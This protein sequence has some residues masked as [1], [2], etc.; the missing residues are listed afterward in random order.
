[1]LA[2]EP[3]AAADVKD[4]GRGCEGEELQSALCH[5]G[6]DRFDS[7]GGG[8]FIRFGVIVE[9]VWGAVAVLVGAYRANCADVRSLQGIFGTG[10]GGDKMIF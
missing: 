8:V 3:G 9:E 5:R 4:H 6:L 1:M 7:R 10:H 2:A